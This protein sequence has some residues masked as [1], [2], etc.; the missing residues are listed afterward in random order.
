M[1]ADVSRYDHAFLLSG[2]FLASGGPYIVAALSP[3]A[4]CA[5]SQVEKKAPAWARGLVLQDAATGR[6]ALSHSRLL[7]TL[8][9]AFQVGRHRSSSAGKK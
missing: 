7:V 2:S 9:A 3:P 1:E 4:T 6:K 5:T 8:V